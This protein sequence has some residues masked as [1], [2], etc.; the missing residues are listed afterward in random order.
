MKVQSPQSIAQSQSQELTDSERIEFVRRLD[1][2][3]FEVTDWEARFIEG[4][5]VRARYRTELATFLSPAQRD[6]IEQL[7][8]QYEH[9]LK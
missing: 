2:A 6:K 1:N 9:R 8:Q 3:P 7:R 5:L 4:L